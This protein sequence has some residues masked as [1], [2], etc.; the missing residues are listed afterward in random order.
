MNLKLLIAATLFVAVPIVAFRN[1]INRR[2]A[3]EADYRGCSRSSSRQLVATKDKLKVILR[4]AKQHEQLDK[5]EEKGDAKRVRSPADKL[6][7]LDSEWGRYHKGDGWLTGEVDRNSAEDQK[8]SAVS[9][10]CAISVAMLGMR[11]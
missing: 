3:L 10:R 1:R 5:A 6:D 11:T 9:S 8:F 2:P 7:G 4:V